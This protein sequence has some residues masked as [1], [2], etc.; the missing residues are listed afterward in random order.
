M[1]V[2]IPAVISA[3]GKWCAYGY[4]SAQDDPDWSMIMEVAD[5]GGDIVG[6]YRRVWI[7]VDLPEPQTAEVVGTVQP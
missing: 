1:K 7:T 4:P 6:D 3:E 5:N 2:R